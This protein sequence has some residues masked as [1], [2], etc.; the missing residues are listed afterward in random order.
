MDNRPQVGQVALLP[1]HQVVAVLVEGQA[2]QPGG[3]AAGEE[4][5]VQLVLLHPLLPGEVVGLVLQLHHHLGVKL[6]KVFQNLRHPLGGHAGED[7]HPEQLLLAHPGGLLEV[8]LHGLDLPHDL[9]EAYAGLGGGD[10]P[11][12]AV[13]DL[14]PQFVLDVVDDVAQAWLGVPH[15]LGRPVME[16][17]S[18]AFKPVHIFPSLIL[19]LC[20]RCGWNRKSFPGPITRPGKIIPH[21]TQKVY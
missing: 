18:A 2:L 17:H 11:L 9:Q 10:P 16:P 5:A 6:I 12:V 21:S 7:A 13:E 8:V 14:D 1:H 15:G 4:A 3:A 19:S 20:V